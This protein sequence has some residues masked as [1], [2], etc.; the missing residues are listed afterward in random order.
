MWK[1]FLINRGVSE[2]VINVTKISYTYPWI[3]IPYLKENLETIKGRWF[4]Y[5]KE[6]RAKTIPKYLWLRGRPEFPFNWNPM[7]WDTFIYICEGELDTILLRAS[8]EYNKSNLDNVIGLP[9]GAST[10]KQPWADI[11]KATNLKIFTLLDNDSAG[12][13]GAQNIANKIGKEVQQVVWPSNNV[14]YD[15]TDFANKSILDLVDRL[16]RLTFKTIVPVNEDLIVHKRRR[17]NL[18]KNSSLEELKKGI[19]IEDVIRR[20]AKIKNTTSGLQVHCPFHVDKVPSLVIYKK[21]NSFY[22]FS[23]GAGG[24][25]LDFL[26]KINGE[27]N[28][29]KAVDFLQNNHVKRTE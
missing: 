15:L 10:F 25:S 24:S 29:S 20:F 19:P 14:G 16:G 17:L 4:G 18:N 23:C 13:K 5:P 28:L 26:M 7:N 6:Q 21:T 11:L 3:R 12:E 2:H 22:C 8:F 27:M 1:K 9:F